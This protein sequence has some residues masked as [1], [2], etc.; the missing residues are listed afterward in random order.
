MIP[1]SQS[2]YDQVKSWGPAEP[3][4]C[5]CS[6]GH[7]G[8]GGAWTH[9]PLRPKAIEARASFG[10]GISP[11]ISPFSLPRLQRGHGPIAGSHPQIRKFCHKE[12]HLWTQGERLGLVPSS[13]PT[14]LLSFP[15]SLI[16][17]GATPPG[18]E[19]RLKEPKSLVLPLHHGAMRWP[20]RQARRVF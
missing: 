5:S 1:L 8:R 7:R 3:T 19:P 11:P 15:N 18:F 16:L 4:S 6:A 14:L 2:L 10:N 12:G 17:S 20:E 13:V 9:P